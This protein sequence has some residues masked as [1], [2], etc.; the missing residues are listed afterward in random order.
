VAEDATKALEQV[1]RHVATVAIDSCNEA[2][3]A[4]ADSAYNVIA[5]LIAEPLARGR[6]QQRRHLP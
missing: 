5:V 6:L 1:C 4:R 3:H 2:G